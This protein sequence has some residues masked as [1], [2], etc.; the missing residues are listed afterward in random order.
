MNPQVLAIVLS[1]VMLLVVLFL[2]RSYVLPEK[3]AVIWLFVALLGRSCFRC[4]PASSTRSPDFFGVAQPINLLFV[5]GFFFV[6]LLL[7]QVE[8]RAGAHRATNS[9]VPSRGSPSTRRK[10][11]VT[12]PEPLDGPTARRRRPWDVARLVG[13][14]PLLRSCPILAVLALGAWA[15]ASPDRLGSRRRLPP[16]QHLVRQRR[17]HGPLRPGPKADERIVPAGVLDAACFAGPADHQ[18]GLS[19][20]LFRRGTAAVHRDRP[21]ATSSTT[22][23][24]CTTPR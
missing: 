18:C 22:T 3:Y 15:F 7:M 4:F 11:R 10:N 6:L 9:A 14:V 17:P 8:P 5:G 24:R 2:L 12:T 20:A 1:V 13:A 16:G 21:A 19:A 23:R